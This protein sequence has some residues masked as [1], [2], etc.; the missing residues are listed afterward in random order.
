MAQPKRGYHHGDL[1]NALISAAVDLAIEGGPP[2][3]TVR[4]AARAVGVTATAAY[5]HFQGRE[6]LL[7]ATRQ[8][9]FDRLNESI[10]TNVARRSRHR[11]TVVDALLELAAVGRGYLD[12]ARRWPGLFRLVGLLVTDLANQP[13][14]SPFRTLSAAMDT[15]VEVGYLPAQR[16][17]YA[18]I[19][20]WA[21]VHGLAMLYLDGPLRDANEE[22]RIHVNTRTIE[23]LAEGLGGHAM[24]Q[25]AIEALRDAIGD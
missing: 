22:V 18:E 16:R 24:P 20:A 15:L 14:D 3:V 10:A 17:P 6:E 4:A 13:E 23:I 19:S 25:A 11:E 9:A 7:D 1:R 5:R 8:L 2:S 21:G 12:F